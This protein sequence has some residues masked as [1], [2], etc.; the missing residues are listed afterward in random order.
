MM[1][2]RL[3][4]VLLGTTIVFSLSSCG[5]AGT[6]N[7]ASTNAKQ[8]GRKTA[9]RKLLKLH[10]ILVMFWLPIFLAPARTMA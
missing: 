7:N 2:K 3:T 6:N 10:R 8:T 1:M 4:A 9:H 5:N